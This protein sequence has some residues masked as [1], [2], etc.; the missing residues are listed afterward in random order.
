MW[1]VEMSLNPNEEKPSS[2]FLPHRPEMLTRCLLQ[3]YYSSH[4]VILWE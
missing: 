4:L 2:I 1:G 3:S